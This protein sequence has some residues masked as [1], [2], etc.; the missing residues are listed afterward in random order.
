[1]SFAPSAQYHSASHKRVPSVVPPGSEFHKFNIIWKEERIHVVGFCNLQSD[2]I[3]IWWEEEVPSS[4]ECLRVGE[5][6]YRVCFRFNCSLSNFR[7][8]A[9]VWKRTLVQWKRSGVGGRWWRKKRNV[10]CSDR[11]I[12]KWESG[13]YMREGRL[14]N[15][16]ERTC[17]TKENTV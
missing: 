1:M 7:R 6:G 13:M 9:L 16:K 11:I 2:S 5:R 14:I 8:F 10:D 15:R 4:L 12:Q 17:A 3:A